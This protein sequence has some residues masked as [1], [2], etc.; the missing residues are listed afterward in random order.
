MTSPR[1]PA[2]THGPRRSTK[3]QETRAGDVAQALLPAAPRLISALVGRQPVQC[4]KGFRGCPAS[5]HAGVSWLATASGTLRRP[6]HSARPASVPM[7][8]DAADRS[9]CATSRAPGPW[10]RKRSEAMPEVR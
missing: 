8:G 1:P 6:R 9:A 7:T 5:T 3:I 2:S 4:R 10:P